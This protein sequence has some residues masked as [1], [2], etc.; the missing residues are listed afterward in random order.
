[1]TTRRSMVWLILFILAVPTVAAAADT[2]QRAQEGQLVVR[3]GDVHEG[4]RF[5]YDLH[6]SSLLHDIDVTVDDWYSV[7]IGNVDSYVLPDGTSAQAFPVTVSHAATP[8]LERHSM[9]WSENGSTGV[10]ERAIREASEETQYLRAQD[11]V[12]LALEQQWTRESWSTTSGAPTYQREETSSRRVGEGVGGSIFATGD[13]PGSAFVAEG[14]VGLVMSAIIP[15]H[16]GFHS[17][18]ADWRGENVY[19]SRGDSWSRVSTSPSLSCSL[20]P[21]LHYTD[22]YGG[23]GLGTV[24][25]TTTTQTWV[26]EGLALPVLSSCHARYLED[27]RLVEDLRLSLELAAH[28]PGGDA[29]TPSWSHEDAPVAKSFA[30]PIE[31]SLPGVPADG[32]PILRYPLSEAVKDVTA[33]SDP[34]LREF[35]SPGDTPFILLSARHDPFTAQATQEEAVVPSL[36]GNPLGGT[37]AETGVSL[38]DWVLTLQNLDGH[39]VTVRAQREYTADDRVVGSSVTAV[40]EGQG[41][42][43]LE[44]FPERLA[45]IGAL[46]SAWTTLRKVDLDAWLQDE[47]A[48]LWVSNQVN[49]KDGAVDPRHQYHQIAFLRGDPQGAKATQG[50]TEW[51]T[52]DATTGRFSVSNR[53]HAEPQEEGASPP[54]SIGTPLRTSSLMAAPYIPAAAAASGIAVAVAFT[55]VYFWDGVSRFAGQAIVAPLHAKIRKDKVLDHRT[56]DQVVE[57]VR[58]NPGAPVGAVRRHLEVGYGTAMHHLNTLERNRFITSRK[59][60][61]ERCYFLAGTMAPAE[62]DGHAAAGTDA[63]ARFLAVLASQP[64]LTQ[65][66]VAERL[67]VHDASVRYQAK[68][69]AAH[70]QI[71]AVRDGRVVRYFPVGALPGTV[72][73]PEVVA[74]PTSSPSSPS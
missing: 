66:E 9:N 11:G 58:L 70:G 27:E 67:G 23:R 73:V 52:F 48:A 49:F 6:F 22:A 62:M 30:E 5:V 21:R 40:S 32:R 50:G 39:I 20:H 8:W 13:A 24:H 42:V 64:G 38:S 55:A 74:D 28:T 15:D 10:G 18:Q 25:E 47:E 12:L 43:P 4:E 56:R 31:T 63:A 71:K 19:D 44:H 34:G 68:R 14:V 35:W 60:G 65:K 26:R 3:L 33:A 59:V 54:P 57:Y 29:I 37:A 17:A 1:M 16:G 72:A 53:Q 69:L 36:P 61:R 51:D 45:S 46:L 2:A 41:P 7:E